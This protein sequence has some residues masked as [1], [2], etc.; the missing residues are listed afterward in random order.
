MR[1]RA[2]RP[3]LR[4]EPPPTA[5]GVVVAALTVAAVTAVIFPLRTIS[6]PASSGVAYMLPVLLVSTIWGLRLGLVTSVASAAAFNFF[7]LPPTGQF[8]VAD[9]ENVV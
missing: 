9:G 3:F 6:P 7:H 1:S 5:V 2:S 4:P 8:T